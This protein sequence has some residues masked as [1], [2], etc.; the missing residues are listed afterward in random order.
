MRLL[1]WYWGQRG[2]GARILYELAAALGERADIET[3]IAINRANELRPSIEALGLATRAD[4]IPGPI[5]LPGPTSIGHFAR[6]AKAD[7]A[8]QV[9]GHPLSYPAMLSLRRAHV[10]TIDMVHDAIAHLGD[11]SRIYDTSTLLAR[12]VADHLIVQSEHVL[13]QV[14]S[15]RRTRDTPATLVPHGPL[16]AGVRRSERVQGR[17]LFAGR[18][19]SYKGLDLLLQAW[20]SV[21]AVRPDAT[22]TI[23]GEG[24]LGPYRASL[25]S[26][27]GSGL[28]LVNR[29]LGDAEMPDLVGSASLLV[30]PYREASQS[31]VATIAQALGVT[32]V[33]TDVGGLREQVRDGVDGRI[34]AARPEALATAIT[35]LLDAPGWPR[36]GAASAAPAWA[37]VAATIAR[38]AE[39]LRP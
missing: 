18:I 38:V 13:A 15:Q 11:R 1:L 36:A 30:L 4:R 25:H 32:I 5:N 14:R 26:L 16:Y 20:P 31:G 6:S 3:L 27:Q 28:T 35:E 33:A 2:G 39:G 8:L 22:L 17:V 10:A 19:R 37:E 34:C 24:D 9:M 21:R 7:V 29:W 12:G 23:A